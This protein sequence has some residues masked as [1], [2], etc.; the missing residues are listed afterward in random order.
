LQTGNLDVGDFYSKLKNLWN[1]LTNLTKVPVCTCSGC[2]CEV[3]SKIMGMYEEDRAHQFILGLNDDLYSTLRSQ[4]LA[5]DPLPLLDQ[6][7]NMTKQEENY[8]KIMMA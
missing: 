5:L 7:F 2:K 1:E 4:I 3:S 6:I 8:K